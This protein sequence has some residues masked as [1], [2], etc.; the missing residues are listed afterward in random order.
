[1]LEVSRVDVRRPRPIL[2]RI[3]PFAGPAAA[4]AVFKRGGAILGPGQTVS[5]VRILMN[6]ISTGATADIANGANATVV[7]VTAGG[8][9]I[10]TA[11]SAVA[12]IT[13][14]AEMTLG[15]AADLV[16]AD[17]DVLLC[18]VATAAGGVATQLLDFIIEIEA[19]LDV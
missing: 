18:Q 16:R 12:D 10:A 3:G 8:D 1:M 4:A 19:Y 15:A 5:A 17:G 7:T 11:T 6:T 13:D 9:T 14:G 2:Y